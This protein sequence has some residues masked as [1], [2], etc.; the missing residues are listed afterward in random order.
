M[1]FMLKYE[2]TFLVALA[3]YILNIHSIIS[4]IMNGL[5]IVSDIM[6]KYYFYM[7]S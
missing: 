7:A 5:M 2:L 6:R 4:L 1:Y 3:A